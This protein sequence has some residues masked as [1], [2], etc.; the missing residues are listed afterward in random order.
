MTSFRK[1]SLGLLLGALPL[2]AGA[3]DSRTGGLTLLETA[4]A[5]ATA[6][7]EAV[8]ALTG[9]LS[10]VAYNPAS[11]TTLEYAQ[12]QSQFETSPGDVRTGLLGGGWTN[13][14]VGFAASVAYLDAG[15]IEIVPTLGPS[16][17]RRAQQDFVGALSA[18][19]ALAEGFR[20]GVT[21]KFLSSRLAEEA[22]ATALA[23]DAGVLI[24]L[25]APGLRLGASAQNVGAGVTYRNVED[26]LPTF[27]RVGLSFEA[28]SPEEEASTA[29]LGG[30]WYMQMG[31]GRSR[32][33][34]GADAIID[35]W[36]AVVGAVGFEWELAR[37]AALR[38]GGRVGGEDPGF[39]GGVGF[40][41]QR[42]RVDYSIQLVDELTDRHRFTLS[43]F[44]RTDGE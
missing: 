16:A 27:Y 1:A 39:T 12:F 11:V 20:L 3:V 4:D 8:T 19:A 31:Q 23:G 33:W 15:T 17:T 25:F 36:G 30:P 21:G 42:W 5:R 34:G 26:P 40:W 22:S 41:L 7:G 24:N 29:G 43:Y 28:R 32:F 14:R 13:Q 44:W 37:R 18:G 38:L 9:D 6:L 35:R 10:G 2:A